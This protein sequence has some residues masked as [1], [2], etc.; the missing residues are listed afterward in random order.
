MRGVQ[1]LFLFI[2][3]FW[4]GLA[5][6]EG[7][8]VGPG[9]VLDI[10]VYEE[11]DLDRVVRVGDDGMVT[12]P[13]IG[14]VQVAGQELGPI[15]DTISQRLQAD[16][17]VNPQVTIHIQEYRSSRVEVLG[18]VKS[19]GVIFLTGPGDLINVLAQA[20]GLVEGAGRFVILTHGTTDPTT[21]GFNTE[22]VD[23]H[24]LLDEG[25]VEL[26]LRIE[27]GDTVFVPR[28]NEIY[29]MGEVN[30]QG[31]VPFESDMSLL[32][33]ITKAGGFAN[34]AALTRVQIVRV[35]DGK[36]QILRIDVKRIQEG[37]GRDVP[38]MPE[39]I[40]TVPKSI[41]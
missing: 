14:K 23:V 8:K 7:Y 31:A 16:Y 1:L 33:A 20:G 12:L 40:V 6:A 35:V 10:K 29:V 4:T 38:L 39:D 11:P 34:S 37:K 25:R 32:Q 15:T 9:D 18:A 26:N 28:R 3:S 5:S 22:R 17:L 13:L 41:F 36:E 19:P 24:A 21:A 27:G 2:L 30:K